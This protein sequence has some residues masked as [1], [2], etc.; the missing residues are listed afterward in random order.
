M[1]RSLLLAGWVTSVCFCAAARAH[2]HPGP[3]GKNP[4]G[5]NPSAG[6]AC[7]HAAI[8]DF[9][10]PDSPHPDA[11]GE[12]YFALNA[13]RTELRYFISIDGLNLKPNPVDRTEPDDIIGI[14]LHLFVPDTVGPHVLN[15]FGLATYDMPAEDDADLVIDYHHR[16]LTGIYDDGDATIDPTTGQP[17]LPFFP[18]P[19][20]PLSSWLDTLFRGDLMVAV[21]TNATGFPAMA[22]H[23]HISQVVP[24]PSCIVLA[25]LSLTWF[26]TRLRSRARFG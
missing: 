18:L 23:G 10:T 6:E 13:T 21:H 19:S 16:T 14:H 4:L 1:I 26:A 3:Q 8:D 20:K 17:Y 7:F 11:S 9:H 2:D 25:T 24:E 22:I 12:S 5:C 15:I